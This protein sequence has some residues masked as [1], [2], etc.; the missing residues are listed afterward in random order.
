MGNS[1]AVEVTRI[2]SAIRCSCPADRLEIER[3][4][5][6][7]CSL[8]RALRAESAH[9]G[10]CVRRQRGFDQCRAQALGELIECRYFGYFELHLASL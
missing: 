7:H 4:Q 10:V 8:P 2:G 5:G 6:T 9:A 3:T 1:A